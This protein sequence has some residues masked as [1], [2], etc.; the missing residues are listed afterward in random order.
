MGA[1][2]IVIL[3]DCDGMMQGYDLELVKAVGDNHSADGV[4]GSR[5]QHIEELIR[6]FGI[7]GVAAGSRIVFKGPYLM[8]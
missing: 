2:E 1:G 3:I 6:N 5:P 8:I 7:I 4:G